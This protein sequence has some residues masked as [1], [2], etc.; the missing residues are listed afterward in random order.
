[1]DFRG[2]RKACSEADF[3]GCR[4]IGTH[5]STPQSG[6]SRSRTGDLLGAIQALCQLSYSPA[7]DKGYGRSAC[8]EVV[9]MHGVRVN[10][11]VFTFTVSY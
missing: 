10:R 8:K 1:M 2:G 11:I 5:F 7:S 9:V 6:A 3:P 4:L